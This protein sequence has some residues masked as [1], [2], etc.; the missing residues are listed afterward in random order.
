MKI[1]SFLGSLMDRLC[2]VAG[3]FI[4]S[5]FPQFMQQYTQRLAGHVEALQ[6]LL[7]QLRQ[8]ASFSHKTLEQ[9]IQKFKD[10]TDTDFSQQ[11]DFM[12]GILN[13]WQELNQALDHL[14][15]SSIWLRPYYF[16]KDLQ[17]DI[18]KS[19]FASFQPGFN[20]SME[21]LCYAG[22][23]MIFGWA[24]Y[25]AISKCVVLGYSRALAIFKQSV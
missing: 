12:Q 3:A 9:Y 19:T 11:A 22:A 6:K 21:G 7:H 5:Q 25:Q 16:L 15:Q 24:L 18:A 17:T 14:T 4:F 8:I 10:S 2:V 20:L 23:G 1:F 13:R